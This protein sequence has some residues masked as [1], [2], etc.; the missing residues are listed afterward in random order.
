MIGKDRAL[1]LAITD[2]AFDLAGMSN[3]ALHNKLTGQTGFKNLT[4]IQLSTKVSRQLR[5]LRVHALVRKLPGQRKYHLTTKSHQIS[6]ALP[7]L[8]N[9]SIAQLMST[10]V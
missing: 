4:D 3:K 9:T 5:L 8:L 6:I 10:A 2:P 7:A 1:L